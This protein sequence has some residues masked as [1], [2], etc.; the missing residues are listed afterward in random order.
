MA[1]GE[2]SV[3]A[4]LRTRI[5]VTIV[6]RSSRDRRRSDV[7]A[8]AQQVLVSLRSYLMAACEDQDCSPR[9]GALGK[10]QNALMPWLAK[11]K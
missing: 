4:V 3:G 11:K 7:V 5:F 10:L 8:R 9:E 2:V 6:P 1:N